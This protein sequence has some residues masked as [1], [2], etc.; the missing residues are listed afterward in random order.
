MT[1]ALP[2]RDIAQ[3]KSFKKNNKSGKSHP[4]TEWKWHLGE[5]CQ[6]EA[7]VFKKE[8]NCL[9]SFYHGE[10]QQTWKFASQFSGQ[11][12]WLEIFSHSQNHGAY[13]QKN[14]IPTF[15]HG[16]GHF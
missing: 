6:E 5:F 10:P 2:S 13:P 4:N 15:K 7:S 14:F 3:N 8:P 12:G 9:P 11:T 16:G 1:A